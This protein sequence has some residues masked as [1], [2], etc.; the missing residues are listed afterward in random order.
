MLS[1]EAQPLKFGS[2][3]GVSFRE[4]DRNFR[5]LLGQGS[6]V[7]EPLAMQI[8]KGEPMVLLFY[9]CLSLYSFKSRIRKSTMY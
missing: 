1:I 8:K 5:D 2:V 7:V 4:A 9:E 3:P 6:M